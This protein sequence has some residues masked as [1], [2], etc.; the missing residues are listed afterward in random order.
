VGLVELF[1]AVLI[2]G[3]SCINLGLPAVAFQRSGDGRFLALSGAN[4]VL[5]LVG[6]LWAWGQLPYNPPAWTGVG[7]PILALVLLVALLL[8]VSTL[9]RRRA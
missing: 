5:V 1:V 4:A 3:V 6:L 8:L 7:L 2:A 9:W